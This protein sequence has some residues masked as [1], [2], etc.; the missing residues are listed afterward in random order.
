M[1]PFGLGLASVRVNVLL[2]KAEINQ[3]DDVPIVVLSAPHH[4]VRRLDVTM[5]EP[6]LV[7]VL[8]RRQHLQQ[9]IAGDHFGE[10]LAD[11]LLEIGDISA[12]QVHYE[13][14][15]HTFAVTIN[16]LGDLKHSLDALQLFEELILLLQ[17]PLRFIG[18]FHLDGDMF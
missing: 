14:A 2:C 7:H 9:N 16:E 3:I 11:T 5:D 17:D 15:L 6:G 10:L 18:L 8:D 1:F 4:K 13:E 12:F